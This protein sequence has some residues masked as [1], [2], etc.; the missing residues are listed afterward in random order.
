MRPGRARARHDRSATCRA[1]ADAPDEGQLVD[2]DVCHPRGGWSGSD[3]ATPH[4]VP[5]ETAERA[6]G[7]GAENGRASPSPRR[8]ARRPAAAEVALVVDDAPDE[9][10]AI[11]TNLLSRRGGRRVFQKIAQRGV[12]ADGPRRVRGEPEAATV[13]EAVHAFHEADDHVM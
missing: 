11:A 3:G 4:A 5:G 2:R 12:L 7:R 13:L 6:G 8:R 1:W 9:E 10:S